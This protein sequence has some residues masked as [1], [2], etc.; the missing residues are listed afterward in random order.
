MIFAWNSADPLTGTNDWIY[1]GASNR[2]PKT[3]LLLSY[4]DEDIEEQGILPPDVFAAP[5][6]FSNVNIL[7]SLSSIFGTYIFSINPSF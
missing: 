4:K 6:R 3:T 2:F 7:I 5:L 1:H